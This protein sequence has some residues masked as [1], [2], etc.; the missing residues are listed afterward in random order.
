MSDVSHV[1]LIVMAG[2]VMHCTRQAPGP[3]MGEHK[4]FEVAAD[5]EMMAGWHWWVWRGGDLDL[6]LQQSRFHRS[7]EGPSGISPFLPA[8]VLAYRR[9]YRWRVEKAGSVAL[10]QCVWG[11]GR[12]VWLPLTAC[13]CSFCLGE[14]QLVH[15]AMH[16]LCGEGSLQGQCKHPSPHNACMALFI[17]FCHSNR[18]EGAGCVCSV[19]RQ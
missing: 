10:Q 5:A 8:R 12:G 3:F 4:F 1:L 17:S 11:G 14:K 15:R 16:A 9:R 19:N 13:P 18:T 7:P 6:Q 2:R